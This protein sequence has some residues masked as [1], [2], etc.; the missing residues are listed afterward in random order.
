MLQVAKSQWILNI[1]QCARCN[2]HGAVKEI[3][4]SF[5]YGIWIQ[6]STIAQCWCITNLVEIFLFWCSYTISPPLNHKLLEIKIHGSKTIKKSKW[7]LKT[8]IVVVGILM[9]PSK[10]TK[11]LIIPPS[12]STKL[13]ISNN[14]NPNPIYYP[15]LKT[16]I[17]SASN[18]L[19]WVHR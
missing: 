10:S 6:N 13:L 15:F 4:P 19:L 7:T 9:I 8:K 14:P 18:L 16:T 2:E 5:D 1:E 12:N 11:S 17:S 3:P